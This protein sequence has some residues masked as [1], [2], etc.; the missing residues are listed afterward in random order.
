M[1]FLQKHNL[2]KLVFTKA[3]SFQTCFDNML[4]RT[5]LLDSLG[6]VVHPTKSKLLPKQEIKIL[7]FL[8]NSVKMTTYLTQEK[9]QKLKTLC[10]QLYVVG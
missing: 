10:K 2:F 8:V 5:S 6:F 1:T 3:Q 4:E 9:R 7:G